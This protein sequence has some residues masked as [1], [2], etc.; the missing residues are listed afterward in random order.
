MSGAVL[1]QRVLESLNLNSRFNFYRNR[2]SRRIFELL[3]YN[4]I[5]DKKSAVKGLRKSGE[6][7]GLVCKHMFL[8]ESLLVL[9]LLSL[10]SCQ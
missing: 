8:F 4:L 2:Q 1:G 3:F 6:L 7:C 5:I 10:S 9:W